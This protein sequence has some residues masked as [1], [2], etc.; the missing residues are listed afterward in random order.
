M[1]SRAKERAK[2]WKCQVVPRPFNTELTPPC[3]QNAALKKKPKTKPIGVTKFLLHSLALSR[4]H[5]HLPA[6]PV[7]MTS[8]GKQLQCVLLTSQPGLQHQPPAQRKK[9]G[10][11]PVSHTRS[12]CSCSGDTCP[13]TRLP[14]RRARVQKEGAASPTLNFC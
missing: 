8:P 11:N 6:W 1:P 10:R 7:S 5:S 4:C 3:S 14:Q 9:T 12:M 13:A 2:S